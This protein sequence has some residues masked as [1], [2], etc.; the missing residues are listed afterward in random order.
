VAEGGG[1]WLRSGGQCVCVW[2]CASKGGGSWSRGAEEPWSRGAGK[3]ES[4]ERPLGSGGRGASRARSGRVGELEFAEPDVS[5]ESEGRRSAVR[6]I[7]GVGAGADFIWASGS[8]ARA[9]PR[10]RKRPSPL[11]PGIQR[12]EV[13]EEEVRVR[14]APPR[15]HRDSRGPT[16][17]I[18]PRTFF[19]LPPPVRG[20]ARDAVASPPSRV[21]RLS[22]SVHAPRYSAAR[23]PY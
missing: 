19:H 17:G 18:E 6:S 2:V 23:R 12:L 11:V 21:I 16:A 5:R 22:R 7:R 3:P 14:P 4:R 10:Q 15:A 9:P 8:S 1:I 20:L 13:P